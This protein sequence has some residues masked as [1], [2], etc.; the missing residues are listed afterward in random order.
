MRS[1][2]GTNQA[3]GVILLVGL[4][5]LYLVLNSD[6]GFHRRLY[7]GFSLSFM[8][9]TAIAVMAFFSVV[10][11]LD[12]Q[13]NAPAKEGDIVSR[14]TLVAIAAIGLGGFIYI[15]LLP[16]VGFLLLTPLYLG[17]LAIL[18]GLNPSANLAFAVIAIT[19]VV[20]TIF[21]TLGFP[22]PHGLISF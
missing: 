12:S 4:G 1:W 11:I 17:G 18:L 5:V 21:W 2:I 7:D 3:F 6:P 13:R 15:F 16:T 9:I 14:A 10:M 20:Y 22:V 19:I 8:P